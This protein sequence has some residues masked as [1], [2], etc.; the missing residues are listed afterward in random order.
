MKTAVHALFLLAL[1]LHH[2]HGVASSSSVEQ[3][4]S[5]YL[6]PSIITG[7]GRG[8]VSGKNIAA[9][10]P[11]EIVSNIQIRDRTSQATQL[12]NYVFASHEDNYHMIKFGSGSL[13]NHQQHPTVSQHWE[14][15][16]IT[17]SSSIRDHPYSNFTKLILGTFRCIE[18]GEELS[19]YYGDN[20]FN[21]FNSSVEANITPVAVDHNKQDSSPPRVV[22]VQDMR[23]FGHC[24]SNVHVALS[25]VEHAGNGLFAVKPF[26]EGDIVVVSPV[27]NL[28][29][30]IID[31]E[32]GV[33]QNYCYA[34]RDSDVVL[35]PLNNG[36]MI[37]HNSAGSANVRIDW[38]SW[39][40]S[41]RAIATKYHF[42]QEAGV[43]D[44]AHL[45][46]LPVEEL[47]GYPFAALD[48][49]FIATRDI[50]ADEEIFV[51]YGSEWVHAWSRYQQEISVFRTSTSQHSC[52]HGDTDTSADRCQALV[53]AP[54]FKQYIAVP[55]RL[56]P[57]HW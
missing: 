6:M 7:A 4:C 41:Y 43:F 19:V 57:P 44:L 3:E 35:F 25:T 34:S 21:R 47:F 12:M 40:D 30:K 9:T 38:F 5:L 37:N 2:H 52:S 26:M 24:L 14:D 32:E 11:I 50:A 13:F 54:V 36:A 20:W 55:E 18:A 46:M 39:L 17:S 15:H 10:S 28:P 29:K 45:M 27:L 53:D 56:Y 42:K 22:D 33:L 48:L 16:D 23:R 31:N 1:T 49:S 51:D 8:I